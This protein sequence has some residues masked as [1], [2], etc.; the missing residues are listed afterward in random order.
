MGTHKR[1]ELLVVRSG[2]ACRVIQYSTVVQY[3]TVQYSTVEDVGWGA[4]TTTVTGTTG[5]IV[6][7]CIHACGDK[8]VFGV[9]MACEWWGKT[10]LARAGGHAKGNETKTSVTGFCLLCD[11]SDI[12]GGGDCA[13]GRA[14][15]RK[16]GCSRV[17]G[18]L[19]M[20][21]C[22]RDYV[23]CYYSLIDGEEVRG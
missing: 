6:L 20:Q 16:T 13:I 21:R 18:W 1:L 10:R 9:R 19:E 23:L 5:A 17:E 14:D 2:S 22:R 12:F 8:I 4:A 7:A 3:S 15:G 11:S